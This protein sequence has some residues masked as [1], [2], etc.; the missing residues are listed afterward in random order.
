M[1][2]LFDYQS[3][4]NMRAARLQPL[5]VSGAQMGQQPLL[6]QLVS[7]MSNAGANLGS[8]GAGMLGL[9]LPEE[10][11]QNSIK[12]VMQQVS[13]IASPLGQA[14]AAY[15]LFTDKGMT[16]EAQ[17][18][19]DAIQK[20]KAADRT[21]EKDLADLES[22]RAKTA[23]YKDGKKAGG[24][25]TGPERMIMFVGDVRRRLTTG[26]P[27]TQDE[28]AQAEDFRTY[29]AKNK[30]YADKDGN[31][32]NVTTSQISPIQPA[33][34]SAIPTKS[35]PPTKGAAPTSST[36]TSNGMTVATNTNTPQSIKAEK[37]VADKRRTLKASFTDGLGLLNEIIDNSDWTTRGLGGDLAALNPYSDSASQ[38]R[39]QQTIMAKL[40]TETL[41]D[42]KSQSATG[43]TGFGALN[44]AE[45]Q[46]IKDQITNL[47][48]SDPNYDKRLLALRERWTNAIAL[49]D[50]EAGISTDNQLDLSQ[51]D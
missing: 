41:A 14:Q 6:S 22:V 29:L 19:M 9:E 25:G 4:E 43:A 3:P 34:G 48:P 31:V 10:A 13:N 51:F 2:G 44:E 46:I 40:V 24:A 21:E 35:A 33:K 45:L 20:L 38:R 30:V 42:L 47:N 26:E 1:A 16:E 18:T 15:Q 8:A 28:I 39:T 11:K 23:F 7:Q 5:L 50:Q 49:I 17:K 37:R 36:V 27:V 32:V 12:Q